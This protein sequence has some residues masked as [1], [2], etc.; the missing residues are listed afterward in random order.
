MIF[1][2]TAYAPQSGCDVAAKQQFREELQSLCDR[3]TDEELLLVLGDMNA[4]AGGDRQGF[5]E[6]VGK[7]HRGNRNAEG[8][9]WKCAA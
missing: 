7:F 2:V 9:Y 8:T 6:N 3:A 1:V 4:H 5:E